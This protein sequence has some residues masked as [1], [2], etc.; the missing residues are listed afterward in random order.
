M[1]ATLSV[2]SESMLGLTDIGAQVTIPLRWR[3]FRVR[4]V[5]V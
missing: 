4:T 5:G 3:L 2:N 1:M